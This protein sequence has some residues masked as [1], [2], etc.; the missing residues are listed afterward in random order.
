MICRSL[1]LFVAPAELVTL[2]VTRLQ[3]STVVVF[4]VFVRLV[5]LVPKSTALVNKATALVL[6]Q[7]AAVQLDLQIFI[8]HAAPLPAA[9]LPTA[10]ATLDIV[11]VAQVSL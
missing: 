3:F 4:G 1:A 8:A 6:S 5:Q 7:S 2:A 9:A 11:I 10:K